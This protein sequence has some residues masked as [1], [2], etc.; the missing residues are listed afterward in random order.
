[1]KRLTIILTVCL[2]IIA[3]LWLGKTK[4]QPKIE[5]IKTVY[6]KDEAEKFVK[7]LDEFG[8]FNYADNSDLDILKAT[9]IKEFD[10][11]AE[12]ITIWDDNTHLP[13][14]FRYYFCDGEEVYEKD[15]IIGL[16]KDLKTVFDKMNF[17]CDI[18]NHFE[19]WDKKSKW[20]NHRITINGTEY[21]VF[22]NFKGYGW[23]EAPFRIAQ[24][25]NIELQKQNIAEQVYLVNGGNDG[26]L[27]LLTK[28]Q[29]DFIYSTYKDKNWKPLEINEW[30]NISKLDIKKY[31]YWNE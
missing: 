8:Y 3:G 31:D 15:G 4:G 23:V 30:A 11:E 1:M 28:E 9:F 27:A 10:P 24:I 20:L 19:E 22:K 21:I 12:L 18:T 26:R 16:L 14:D 17:K 25:L 5:R 6:N 2:A 29:Y 13:K 7:R